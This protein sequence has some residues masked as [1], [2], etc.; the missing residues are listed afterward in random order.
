MTQKYVDIQSLPETVHRICSDSY[1]AQ[2]C[3]PIIFLTDL[4]QTVLRLEFSEV[5]I[6]QSQ[7][8]SQD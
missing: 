3:Q 4:C 7:H 1:H 5:F 8:V 2:I 6:G